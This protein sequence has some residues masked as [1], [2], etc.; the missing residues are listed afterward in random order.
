[1]HQA[2]RQHGCVSHVTKAEGPLQHCEKLE[3]E[4]TRTAIVRD[5]LYLV[6]IEQVNEKGDR[7]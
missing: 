1:M 4:G 5:R 3:V 6:I 7:V 2:R